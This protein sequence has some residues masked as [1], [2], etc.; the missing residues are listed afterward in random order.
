MQYLHHR[1]DA[2]RAQALESFTKVGRDRGGH[3]LASDEGKYSSEDL[4]FQPV[5]LLRGDR[6]DKI[7]QRPCE[8]SVDAGVYEIASLVGEKFAFE[9]FL[10]PF[11]E[12]FI[13]QIVH[14]AE[15]VLAK[16]APFFPGLKPAWTASEPLP[17]GDIGHFNRFRDEMHG[18]YSRLGRDLV[19]GLVRRHGSR[20]TRILGD[21]RSIDDLGRHYGAGLTER[22]LEYLRAEEWAATAEDVLWRRTKCGL[23]MSADERRAVEERF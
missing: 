7:R 12:A 15:E 21:A 13:D 8:S 5:E 11:R 6:A 20:A 2:M 17:G 4:S 3:L 1:V 22:E 18:K 23:H 10:Y 16:V 9:S 19:D 14:L